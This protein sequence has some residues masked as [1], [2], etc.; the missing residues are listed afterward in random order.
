M[1]NE[2]VELKKTEVW[3]MMFA[4][5]KG[6]ILRFHVKNVQDVLENYHLDV[7]VLGKRLRKHLP[8]LR[9]DHPV[10]GTRVDGEM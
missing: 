2:R 3:K 9:K 7:N 1:E 4:F 8:F 10:K 6:E 5:L